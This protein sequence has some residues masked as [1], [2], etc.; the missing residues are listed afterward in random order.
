MSLAAPCPLTARH[1][2]AG[3]DCGDTSLNEWLRRRAGANQMSGASRTYVA[4][5]GGTIVGYYALAAGAVTAA[6]A[7]G[8]FRRNMPDPTIPIVLLGRLAVDHRFQGR[9]LGR[10][11]FRDAALRVMSAA[12]TIGVRGLVVHALSDEARAFYLALG[13][14]AAPLDPLTLLVTVAE[15]RAAL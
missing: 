8:A 1:D 13:L 9:G 4:C 11:L 5:D 15:L 2:V 3:F 10:A 14:T 12:E 6:Q 7:P